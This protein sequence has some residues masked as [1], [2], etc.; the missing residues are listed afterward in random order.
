[1]VNISLD[2]TEETG[3]AKTQQQQ[4]IDSSPAKAPIP[5]LLPLDPRNR[6][7]SINTLRHAHNRHQLHQHLPQLPHQRLATFR[8][9]ILR[10][11]D[12]LEV[13]VRG[14]IWMAAGYDAC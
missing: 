10:P 7:N 11:G 4:R 13:Q 2:S 14:E 6:K 9:A 8:S 5:I 12:Q 3:Q 1:M